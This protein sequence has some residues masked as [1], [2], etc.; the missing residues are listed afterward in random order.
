MI[1]LQF[2][3]KKLI[4]KNELGGFIEDLY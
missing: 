4:S 1:F 3:M 2:E